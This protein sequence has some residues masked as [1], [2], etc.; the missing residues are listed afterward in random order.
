MRTFS[1]QWLFALLS[2]LGFSCNNSTDEIVRIDGSNGLKPLIQELA[3]AYQKHHPDQTIAVGNGMPSRQRLPALTADSIQLVMASHGLDVPRLQIDGY[4][5]YRFAQMPIVWGVHHEVTIDSIDGS[6]LC[7]I[8]AGKINNWQQLGGPDLRIVPMMRPKNEV[9]MEVILEKLPCMQVIAIDTAVVI[10]ESSG[11][12]AQSL[13][14]T[15]GSI[16]MTSLTR[17]NQS[18][19][20]IKTLAFNGVTPTPDNMASGTYNLMRD[21][22][23]V[24]APAKRPEV[25]R[26]IFFV[27]GSQG[28]EVLRHS[29]ALP[30]PLSG[31]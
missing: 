18:G 1:S 7:G 20:L 25:D 28:A 17:V 2:I 6:S 12:M 22:Y 14:E 30:L 24:S 29:G 8:Y 11:D 26:F 3:Q 15:P 27:E 4:H 23:L 19:N 13:A 5:V 9:D 31:N 10:R 16:G 21:A